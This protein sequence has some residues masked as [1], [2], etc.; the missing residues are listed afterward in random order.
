[1]YLVALS[2]RWSQP[3]VTLYRIC[4]QAVEN[5]AGRPAQTLSEDAASSATITAI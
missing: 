1:M 5:A 4:Y 2:S 3:W